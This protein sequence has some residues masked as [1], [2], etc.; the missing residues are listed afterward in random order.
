MA[1]LGNK[2]KLAAISRETP[3]NTRN[4]QSRKANDSEMAE[5]YIFH[6]LMKSKGEWLKNSQ[7]SSVGQSLVSWVL[8]QN[9]GQCSVAVPGTSR[10]SNSENR[11]PTGARSLDDPCPETRSSSD[12]SGNLNSSEVENYP[13][14]VT[15]DPEVFAIALTWWQKFKRRFR[16]APLGFFKENKRRRAP[17]VSHNFAVRTSLRQLKQT[18]FC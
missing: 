2:R 9:F 14:M 15:R 7:R 18:R 8:C 6:F 1:T 10:N 12:H 11:E 3:E 13:H 17:Q 4:S 5:Q 16:T